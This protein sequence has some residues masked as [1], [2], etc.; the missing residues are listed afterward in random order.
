MATAAAHLVSKERILPVC[1]EVLPYVPQNPIDSCFQVENENLA[2]T[3]CHLEELEARLANDYGM[4]GDI[5]SVEVFSETKAREFTQEDTS[6]L[7]AV[8]DLYTLYQLRVFASCAKLP[9]SSNPEDV[10]VPFK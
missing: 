10:R 7:A 5:D 8:K 6:S 3:M 2:E 1:R 4:S 9:L